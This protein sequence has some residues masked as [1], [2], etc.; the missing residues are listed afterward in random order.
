MSD[1]RLAE[2]ER[3][4]REG[5]IEDRARFLTERLRA[6]LLSIEGLSLAA[7]MGDEPALLAYQCPHDDLIDGDRGCVCF[8]GKGG[9]HILLHHWAQGIGRW[10]SMAKAHAAVAAAKVVMNYAD[11][12]GH[13]SCEGMHA[14]ALGTHLDFDC[15]A[16]G[17]VLDAAEKFL[18]CPCQACAAAWRKQWHAVVYET[19]RALELSWLPGPE[20]L[21]SDVPQQISLAASIVGS[22]TKIRAAIRAD[23]LAWALR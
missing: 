8:Y 23:L 15:N 16:A 3:A 5:T 10:G 20:P 11:P 9:G 19:G 21:G 22:S 7:F 6:G 14:S 2:L 4:A 1:R 13:E 12:S 18:D 17:H